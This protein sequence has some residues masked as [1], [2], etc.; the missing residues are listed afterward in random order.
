MADINK[1]ILVGT[2]ITDPKSK[3]TPHQN[4]ITTMRLKTRVPFFDHSGKK[5]FK[6][7]WH[8]IVVWNSCANVDDLRQYDR[9]MVEG[10]LATRSWEEEG[11]RRYVTEVLASSVDRLE[12]EYEDIREEE[13]S[14]E[15]KETYSTTS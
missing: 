9:V 13:G 2:L 3:I 15:E 5:R 11:K 10:K 12:D 8:R 7:E 1:V 6:F 14:E 4:K